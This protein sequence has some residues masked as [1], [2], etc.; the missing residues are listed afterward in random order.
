LPAVILRPGQIFGPGGEHFAPSGTISLAGRWVVVG[1][2]Y[3]RLPLVFVED[4][5]DALL[6]ARQ[7]PSV[8]GATFNIVDAEKVNQRQYIAAYAQNPKSKVRVLYV[9]YSVMFFGGYLCDLLGK[10]LKRG[11]PLSR[12]RVRSIRP[13]SPFDLTAAE[14]TLGWKPSCGTT[15]GMQ[16]S[17]SRAVPSAPA[18]SALKPVQA[19]ESE[20]DSQAL[21]GSRESRSR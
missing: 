17:F 8:V 9:P 21:V 3:A 6:L 10:V 7:N 4:V 12:Y 19:T 11:L 1:G 15:R 5:V 20:E 14:K 2:G 13:L 16:I 18:A